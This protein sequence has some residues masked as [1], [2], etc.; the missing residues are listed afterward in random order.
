MLKLKEGE[1]EKKKKSKMKWKEKGP[2]I[3]PDR[4]YNICSAKH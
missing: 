3:Q 1:E 4:G 2:W